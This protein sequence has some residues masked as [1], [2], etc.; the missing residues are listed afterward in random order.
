MKIKLTGQQEG[1]MIFQITSNR[2][3]KYW[4]GEHQI[5][6]EARDSLPG[7]LLGVYV[8]REP[9]T[10][11]LGTPTA[12][13]IGVIKSSKIKDGCVEAS[14]SIDFLPNPS[15]IESFVRR[16]GLEVK[17]IQDSEEIISVE[18]FGYISIKPHGE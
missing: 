15:S 18:S 16:P 8:F 13:P 2:D 3:S 17:A 10:K 12:K 4:L 5:S 7:L 9:P 14:T 6:S 11:R 1:G